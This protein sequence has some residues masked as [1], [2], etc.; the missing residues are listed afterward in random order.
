[1]IESGY[2]KRFKEET[3]KDAVKSCEIPDLAYV[4]YLESE[5]SKSDEK[6][7]RERISV[8]DETFKEYVK[9]IIR[10][11]GLADTFQNI[12]TACVEISVE[13]DVEGIYPNKNKKVKKIVKMLDRFVNK[14]YDEENK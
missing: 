11:N 10:Q 8:D 9:K 14:V 2:R 6:S 4:E 13:L 3:N 5:L 7:V 1:M 12:W